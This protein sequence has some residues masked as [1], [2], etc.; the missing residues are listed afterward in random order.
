[1]RNGNELKTQYTPAYATVPVSNMPGTYIN[2]L[3]YASSK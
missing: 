3:N 2:I 1:M